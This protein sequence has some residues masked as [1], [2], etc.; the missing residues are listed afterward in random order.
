MKYFFWLLICS[1]HLAGAQKI[2]KADKAILASLETH[3]SYLADDKLEGRRTG[4]K[5]EKLAYEYIADQFE[6][7][8]L[9]VKGEKNTYL[10]EFEVNDGKE[11]AGISHLI[12]N[13]NDLKLNDEYF[14]FS[15]SPDKSLEANTSIALHETASPW[16]YDIKELL[17][18]NKNNPHFDLVDGIKAQAMDAEK[19]GANAFVIFNTS[20]IKDDLKFEPKSK[21]DIL[22]IPV[23][24]ILKAAKEKYLKDETATLDVKLKV[25]IVEK[26]RYGH[27]V[28]GFINN[29]AATTIVLGAHY[30]HLGYGEDHNSLYTGATPQIHNGA[31]D[32]ASGTGALIEL[33]IDCESCTAFPT[34]TCS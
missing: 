28:I 20:T 3:I 16:F 2:K 17:D 19:K 24:Y 21:A 5:G 12:I 27:N 15:F 22:S 11:V 30:D 18:A 8:G 23:L 31:D 7:A 13:D 25:A 26:K 14:P 9:E 6:K 4:S 1:F 29:N 33:S 32:N 34:R 10:Q